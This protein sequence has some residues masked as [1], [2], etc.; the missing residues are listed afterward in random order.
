MR[1]AEKVQEWIYSLE[2]EDK[3]EVD[4]GNQ[5]SQVNFK[6]R[7]NEQS[8]NVWVE[9][10]EQTDVVKAYIYAPFKVIPKKSQEF[11]L[12]LNRINTEIWSGSFIDINGGNICW[13]HIVNFAD[14]DPS[15]KTID[16]LFS[17]GV[18]VYQTWFEEISAVALTKTTAQDIFDEL[19][20]P[21]ESTD[22]NVPDEI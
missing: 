20:T 7:I 18:F 6:Y 21:S 19:D 12:L 15:I 4:E 13:R 9:T 17:Y 22:E 16:N 1:L 8:F 2:W 10:D 3:I 14:T 11:A 5:T